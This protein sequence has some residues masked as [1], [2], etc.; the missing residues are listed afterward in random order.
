[1]EGKQTDL[2]FLPDLPPELQAHIFNY[3]DKR[4]RDIV[5]KHSKHMYNLLDKDTRRRV[6]RELFSESA[7]LDFLKAR[8]QLKKI[9]ASLS[10]YWRMNVDIIHRS[11]SQPW[12]THLFLRLRDNVVITCNS[13]NAESLLCEFLCAWVH[14][15]KLKTYQRFVSQESM[16]MLLAMVQAIQIQKFPKKGYIKWGRAWVTDSQFRVY[17]QKGE[18]RVSRWDVDYFWSVHHI[19]A[20]FGEPLQN[21]Q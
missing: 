3:V 17:C 10:V 14:C 8:Q 4:K 19:S 1:M 2:S 6:E 21:I 7:L 18:F 12:F 13:G 16:P 9:K 15:D 11:R 20:L 5:A